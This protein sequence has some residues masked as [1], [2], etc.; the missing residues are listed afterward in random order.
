MERK[1]IIEYLPTLLQ[2]FREFKTITLVEQTELDKMLTEVEKVLNNQFVSDADEVGVSR[3]E[4]ILKIQ[5][6]ATQTLD[7]RKFKILAV[8][9]AT[10]PYTTTTLCEQL[11]HLCGKN[12]YTVNLLN[13][14]YT[15]EVKVELTAKNNFLSVKEILSNTLPCNMIVK[16]ELKYNQHTTLSKLTNTQMRAYT[17]NNLRNEVM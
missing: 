16:L 4:K 5:K 17:H 15:I 8:I 1:K 10:I 11:E 2:E 14:D 12:G 13:D 3:Y 7:E 9:N 6:K